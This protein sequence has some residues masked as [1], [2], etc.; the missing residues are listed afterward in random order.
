MMGSR[1]TLERHGADRG[2][3]ARDFG[4]RRGIIDCLSQTNGLVDFGYA[5]RYRP[6]TYSSPD[7]AKRTGCPCGIYERLLR[8]ASR[9]AYPVSPICTGVRGRVGRGCQQRCVDSMPSKRA[10]SADPVWKPEGAPSSVSRLCLRSRRVVLLNACG[11]WAERKKG[12]TVVFP[13]VRAHA[14]LKGLSGYASLTRPTSA[15]V[16]LTLPSP[17][18]GRGF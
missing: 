10:W 9:R 14:S 1:M 7:S 8:L 2:G 16:P 18:V 15:S 13:L 5:H 3:W 11:S 17:T 12:L 4:K 6:R